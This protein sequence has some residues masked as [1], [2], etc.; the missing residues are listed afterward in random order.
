M[1]LVITGIKM[2]A[3]T[4]KLC[5]FLAETGALILMADKKDFSVD[6]I[7]RSSCFQVEFSSDERE[8]VIVRVIIKG[9]KMSYT[10]DSADIDK[11]AFI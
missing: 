10:F 1:D 3:I 2:R 4:P 11:V 7:I 6:V 9:K 5:D 8:E